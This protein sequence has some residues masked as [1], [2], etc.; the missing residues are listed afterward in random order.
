MLPKLSV[1]KTLLNVKQYTNKDNFEKA[2]MLYE[3]LVTFFSKN[4]R[5]CHEFG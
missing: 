2:K 4:K 3:E 1:D 5:A